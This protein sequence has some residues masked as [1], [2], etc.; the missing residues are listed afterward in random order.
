MS[1]PNMPQPPEQVHFTYAAEA[2]MTTLCQGD[3]LS[4]T[5]DLR[6]VL[7]EVHPYFLGEQYKYFMVLSQSCDLVRRN[8]SGCKTA[9]ITLAAVRSYDDLLKR[10]F[11]KSRYAEEIGGILLMDS[12]NQTRAYQFI[13]RLYNNTESEYFFLYKDD[14]LNFPESMVAS[15]KVSIALKS[16][17]HYDVCLK[18]KIMELNEAFKAK[19]GWLVGNMYSRV[20]TADWENIMAP[21]ERTRML[22]DELTS[23][24]VIGTKEQIKVLKERI[25]NDGVHFSTPEEAADYLSG[26]HVT[27]RY[28]QVLEVIED[29]IKTAPA[30]KISQESKEYLITSIRS[31]SKLKTLLKPQK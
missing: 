15:L 5:E 6:N 7:E 1:S 2:D 10:E 4:V 31:R 24:C 19:L 12:K 23:H 29:A 8:K 18:A 16:S 3:I 17:L 30:K 25:S 28:D 11:I 20:G 22:N 9:Y 27:T 14:R 21:S 13:E 26:I